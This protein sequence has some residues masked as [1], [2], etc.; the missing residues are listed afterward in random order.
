MSKI[1]IKKLK[2]YVE[3][4]RDERTG[5]AFIEDGTTGIEYSAH[6]NIDAS[7]SVKGM[8]NRGYWDKNDVTTRSRGA[9]YN[10]S[11]ISVTN[12]YDEIALEHCQCTICKE[13]KS[14]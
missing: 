7:G 11:K 1:L 14:K 6:P 4:F 12:K 3:L 2:P 9:I 8:K 13:R 5:I 10:L